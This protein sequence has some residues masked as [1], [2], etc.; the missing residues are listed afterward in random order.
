M[1]VGYLVSRVE[2]HIQTID[3]NKVA[4]KLENESSWTYGKLNEVS[5]MYADSLQNMGVR[6][7]DRIGILLYNRL[8]YVALYFAIAKLGAIAV[9]LNFRLVKEELEYALN[10]SGTKVL[11]FDYKLIDTI[12]MVKDAVQVEEYICF[13]EYDQNVPSWSN[14]WEVAMLNSSASYCGPS[15]KN[16]EAAIWSCYKYGRD[17]KA[18][19]L[20]EAIDTNH[21][22]SRKVG[23]FFEE[24]DVFLTPTIA[25]LPAKIGQLD[26]NHQEINARE[27]TEQ[28]F[29]YAPFTNLFNATGQPSI[30]LPLGWSESGLPIGMQFTGKFADETTLLQLASQLEEAKPWKD[31]HPNIHSSNIRG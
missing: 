21:S 4:L 18:S 27:W 9:R 17:M 22:V 5:N 2:N 11:C 30:S 16:I 28:I 26:A 31:K 23:H 1:N 29:T 13:Q 15:E 19:E 20:L 6:K 8:E 12:Q 10:D 14:S 24:Y 3:P 7:G 25:T